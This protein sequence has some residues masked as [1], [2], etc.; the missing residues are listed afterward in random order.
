MGCP[1]NVFDGCG[2]LSKTHR[3][4]EAKSVFSS[5]GWPAFQGTAATRWSRLPGRFGFTIGAWAVG[6]GHGELQQ[7]GARI[8]VRNQFLQVQH[9]TGDIFAFGDLAKF[10]QSDMHHFEVGRKRGEIAE[11]LRMR[12]RH[13]LFVLE[14]E[15]FEELLTR[16]QAGEFEFDIPIGPQSGEQNKITSEIYDS[17]GFA[18]IEDKD[19]SAFSYRECLQYELSGLRNGHEVAT[20]LRVSNRY[21][22]RRRQSAL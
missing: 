11:N 8:V 22:A 17:D 12:R 3:A 2:A 9:Q 6:R 21:R 16:T 4:L 1:A 19:L 7:L 10:F 15:F 14:I 13:E 18:H 20:H 5:A